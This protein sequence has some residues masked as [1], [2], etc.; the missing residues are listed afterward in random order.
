[1]VY[2]GKSEINMD[3]LD[4]DWGYPYILSGVVAPNISYKY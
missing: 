2:N 1:M 4:D 3:D